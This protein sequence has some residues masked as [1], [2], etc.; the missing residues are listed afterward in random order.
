MGRVFW[1]V[2][3]SKTMIS[4]IKCISVFHDINVNKAFYIKYYY[5]FLKQYTKLKI[6]GH[7][8]IYFNFMRYNTREVLLS[9]RQ[10]F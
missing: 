1:E 8:M 7:E 4:S 3:I 2:I 5:I 10:C 6:L 9:E